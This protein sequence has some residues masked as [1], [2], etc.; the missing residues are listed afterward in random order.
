LG[1]AVGHVQMTDD[2]VLGNVMLSEHLPTGSSFFPPS[3]FFLSL[4]LFILLTADTASLY[5]ASTSSSPSSK[6]TGKT[7]NHCTSNQRW[8]NQSGSSSFPPSSASSWATV[9]GRKNRNAQHEAPHACT[10]GFRGWEVRLGADTVFLSFL[11]RDVATRR[12][13]MRVHNIMCA[14]Y[15]CMQMR[16]T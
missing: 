4:C 1:V 16:M 15:D 6:R 9:K 11:F 12:G 3:F 8:A 5:Q 13:S 7:S 2:Q 14:S 10:N